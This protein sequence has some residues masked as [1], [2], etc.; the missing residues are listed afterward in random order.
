MTGS[1]YQGVDGRAA[2]H[3]LTAADFAAL[4]RESLHE[5]EGLRL[6]KAWMLGEA[7]VARFREPL[8][9]DRVLVLSPSLGVFETKYELP[10]GQPVPR[11]ARALREVRGARLVAIRQLGM[12]RVA[13]LTLEG[14][15]WRRELVVEWVREGNVLV[16]GE[17][18]RIEAAL[19]SREMRDRRVMVGERYVPPPPRGLDPLSLNKLDAAELAGGAGR[20][21]AAAHLSRR[22]NAP[23]E[24]VAEA[25]YRAGVD[26]R[27]PARELSVDVLERALEEL[28]GMYL[29]ILRLELEPCVALDG[30]EPVAAYPLRLEHL[31]LELREAPSLAEAV[32]EVYVKLLIPRRGRAGRAGAVA[33]A[34]ARYEARAAELRRA[35]EAVMSQLGRYEEILAEFRRLRG[36]VPWDRVA[37]ELRRRYPEVVA[38]D[39]GAMRLVVRVCGVEVEL[40]ASLSAARNASRLYGEAKELERKAARA[41]EVAE[42]MRVEEPEPITLKRRRERRWYEGFRHFTSSEGVLVIGGRDAGQN[43]AIVRKSMEPGDVFLPADIYGGPVVVVKAGGREP[44]EATL[45]EAAQFAAAYSRAW[46]AGLAAVDVYWVWGRQVSKRAPAGEYLGR[47]AFMVYGRRNYLRRVKLELA[48]GVRVL[49]GEYELLAGPPSAILG[50]CDAAV[51][52]EPGRLDR[53]EAADKVASLLARALRARGVRARISRP[54]VLELLPRGGFYISRVVGLDREA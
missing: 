30:G 41:R 16:V 22:I 44:G 40:D 52:L 14:R 5:L 36:S 12:D 39:P 50:R 32:D 19:R 42:E 6:Q 28:R 18:G 45:R 13:A 17:D 10:R 4:L 47:G 51:V 26:P 1:D 9:G 21:T 24:L 25:L 37:D 46:E 23:G 53:E 35:A 49:D 27:A 2:K 34:A 54:E 8:V 38:A 11:L 33:E 7:V 31:G 20:L 43:E 48:V 15:G 29:R 3:S